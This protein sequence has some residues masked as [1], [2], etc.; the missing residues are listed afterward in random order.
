MA[1]LLEDSTDIL[2]QLLKFRFGADGAG[3]NHHPTDCLQ[4][5]ET[6][7]YSLA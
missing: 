3:E 7:T 1:D 5:T 2:N 6:E 4:A